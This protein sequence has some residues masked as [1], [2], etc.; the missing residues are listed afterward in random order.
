MK[1]YKAVILAGGRGERLKPYTNNKPKP[2]VEVNGSP[3]VD[4]ILNIL[5]KNNI[6]K[7]LFLTGYRSKLITQRYYNCKKL[8]IEFSKGKLN[9]KTGKRI[10]NAYHKLDK[11]FLLLYG[12]IFYPLNLNLLIKNYKKNRKPVIVTIFNNKNGTSE[13]GNKNNI[14]TIN[15]MVVKYDKSKND[16]SCNGVDIGY[17]IIVGP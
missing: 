15:N 1:V 16:N 3:F 17:Y 11:Y 2:L 8:N 10:F 4:Y 9:W 14:K 5:F 7:I 13:Y 12:D 6:T